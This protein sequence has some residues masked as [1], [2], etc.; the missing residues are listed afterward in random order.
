TLVPDVPTQYSGYMP[1]NFDRSYRGMVPAD[2]ALAQS[3]NVPA[4]RM[5]KQ[6]RVERFYDFLRNA[7]MTTLVRPPG[8]Y[9]LTL[10]LGGAEGTLWDISTQYAN[11]AHI[12]RQIYP[13]QS[14][15]YR[16]LRVLLDEDTATQRTSEIGAASA[17]LTL[18]ALREVGRPG[19]EANWRNFAT[20][21]KIAWKTGTSWGLRDAWS[22]GNTSRF[23][24]GVWV[25]NASGE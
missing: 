15:S 23:T 21:K 11:L 12:A 2:V 13:G 24:V 16:R 7:G 14:I 17:W 18:R 10:I 20:A 9:G 22:V 6:H 8:D 1:E 4:V 3:L 19:E 25:G 5:L